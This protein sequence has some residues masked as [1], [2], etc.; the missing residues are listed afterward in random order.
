[1]AIY[2]TPSLELIIKAYTTEQDGLVQKCLEVLSIDIIIVV[3]IL[4][5]SKFSAF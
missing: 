5:Y 4:F 1:M 2:L 3:K